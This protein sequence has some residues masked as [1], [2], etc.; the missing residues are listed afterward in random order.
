MAY[1]TLALPYVLSFELLDDPPDL[2]GFDPFVVGHLAQPIPDAF[3]DGHAYGRVAQSQNPIDDD[4]PGSSNVNVNQPF[5]IDVYWNLSGPL[6]PAFCGSWAVTVFFESMG[7]DDYDFQITADPN[8]DYGCASDPL[9]NRNQRAY[10]VS[11]IVPQG[12]VQVGQ[13]SG[14]PYELNVSLSLL[15]T[16]CPNDGNP[17]GI[18]GSIALEDILFFS[19]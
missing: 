11:I 15:A 16:Q 8:I 18:V 10:H 14:T 6:I 12:T 19:A 4:T 3:V 17:T 13:L 7:P 9:N 1:T 2:G 5:Q